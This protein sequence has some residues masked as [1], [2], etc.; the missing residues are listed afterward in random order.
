[1]DVSRDF[2]MVSMNK[3]SIEGQALRCLEETMGWESMLTAR[4]ITN[5][6]LTNMRRLSGKTLEAQGAMLLED[7]G[8]YYCGTLLS[9]L[10]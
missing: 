3:L 6:D 1:M 7:E 4:L 9:V 2:S 5:D 8:E 10:R